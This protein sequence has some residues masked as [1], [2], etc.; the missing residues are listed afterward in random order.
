MQIVSGLFLT[1]NKGEMKSPTQTQNYFSDWVILK[2][3][4]P[5]VSSKPFILHN[6]YV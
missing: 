5:R 3:G 1:K 2:H 4:F 6:T